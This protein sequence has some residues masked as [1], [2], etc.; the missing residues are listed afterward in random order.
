MTT[1]PRLIHSNDKKSWAQTFR[2]L[3]PNVGATGDLYALLLQSTDQIFKTELQSPRKHGP[4]SET[5]SRTEPD[6]D[7]N[8]CAG[9]PKIRMTDAVQAVRKFSRQPSAQRQKNFAAEEK[10][11]GEN[12]AKHQ[13]CIVESAA[14]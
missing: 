3:T 8:W 12:K 5:K 14:R 9:V 4:Q 2:P 13:G 1:L 6:N 11:E 10:M 7:L